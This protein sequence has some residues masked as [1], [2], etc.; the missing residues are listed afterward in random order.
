MSSEFKSC[1]HRLTGEGKGVA[2]SGREKLEIETQPFV[3][4]PDGGQGD[5]VTLGRRT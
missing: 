4:F 5:R 3:L 1:S 2:E